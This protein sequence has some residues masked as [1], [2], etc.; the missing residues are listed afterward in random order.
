MSR[1]RFRQ[2]RL[3]IAA[4]IGGVAVL[5]ICFIFGYLFFNHLHNKYE[6]RTS[7]I[8]L[9]LNEAERR[10]NEERV[11]VTVVN[12]S[13][14]AGEKLLETDLQTISIPVST[15]PADAVDKEAIVGKYSKITLQQNAVITGSMLFEEGVTPNDLRIQEFRVIELPIKLQKNDFVDVRIKFP[16]GQDYI[17]LSKKKVKDLVTGTIWYEMSEKEIL[18]MSSAIVDA[19]INDASIYALSYVDPYMQDDAAVTY[20][21]NPLVQD[22]I[23]ADPNIVET[24]QYEMERRARTK[25]EQDLAS[26][27]PED[28]Q[29]YVSGKSATDSKAYE[30]SMEETEG[31]GDTQQ[32]PLLDGGA[33]SDDANWTEAGQEN[34]MMSSEQIFSDNSESV[35]IKK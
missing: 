24:A 21:P 19:Y 5:L 33:G 8:E 26:M 16:T 35:S 32:N 14:P 15:A 30:Y 23:A 18:T 34:N 11:D 20:P 4:L 6:K 7:E 1:I 9:K 3:L 27:S 28:V 22:L 10:L 13:I 17:V 12:K 25:L 2:K 29:S 31:S